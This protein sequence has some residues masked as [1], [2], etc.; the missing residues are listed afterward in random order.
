MK[1]VKP[2]KKHQFGN[3][4]FNFSSLIL[5]SFVEWY[6]F[7]FK[8]VINNIL[9]NYKGK[10]KVTHAMLKVTCSDNCWYLKAWF[11]YSVPPFHPSF[12]KHWASVCSE[13]LVPSL[14]FFWLNLLLKVL[15]FQRMMPTPPHR[16]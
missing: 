1:T 3:G 8:V 16:L 14:Q 5:V 4:Y 9:I 10:G 6:V 7:Y 13:Q 2:S 15:V 12:S 11:L